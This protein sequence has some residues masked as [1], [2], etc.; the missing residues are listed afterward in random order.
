MSAEAEIRDVIATID[1]AWRAKQLAGL[2]ACF[3]EDAVIVGPGYAEYAR[4][5][6][7]CA[8]SYREFA[9]NAAVLAYSESAH[10]LRV[11]GTTAVYTFS[12]DM[13]YQRERGPRQEAGTDQLVFELAEG[14]W[15]VVWR[16]IHFR[17]AA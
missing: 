5:R 16:Y 9:T 17:P 13:T 10:V 6:A 14:R 1:A 12:W 15:Q 7:R 2:E 3:H 11:W 4:G 8:E